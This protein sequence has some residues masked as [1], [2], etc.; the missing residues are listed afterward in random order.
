LEIDRARNGGRILSNVISVTGLWDSIRAVLTA[1]TATEV[2]DAVTLTAL[3]VTAAG[4]DEDDRETVVDTPP[5]RVDEA[6]DDTDVVATPPRRTEEEGLV[7]GRGGGH[8]PLILSLKL[9]N[10]VLRL[11][12]TGVGVG[13]GRA[14]VR[15]TLRVAACANGQR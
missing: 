15:P 13:E 1:G 6:L 8:L 9:Q 4:A 2:D 3:E 14:V 7:G 10:G 11:L 5:R 12:A